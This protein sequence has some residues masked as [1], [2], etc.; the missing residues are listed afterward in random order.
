M[1]SIVVGIGGIVGTI[2]DPDVDLVAGFAGLGSIIF[3]LA[4]IMRSW[5]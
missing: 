4:S 1:E 3:V 5:Y 2:V